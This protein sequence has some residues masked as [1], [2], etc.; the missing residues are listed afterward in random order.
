M[1]RTRNHPKN[2]KHCVF[3]KYWMGNANLEFRSMAVGYEYD[4]TASGKCMKKN[5]SMS[6]NSMCSMYAPSYEATKLL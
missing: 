5:M 4:I 3:C 1:G 2:W 6:A